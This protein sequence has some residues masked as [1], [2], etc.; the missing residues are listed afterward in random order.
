MPGNYEILVLGTLATQNYVLTVDATTYTRGLNPGETVALGQARLPHGPCSCLPADSVPAVP[1]TAKPSRPRLR[2]TARLTRG[3]CPQLFMKCCNTAASA[4]PV[5]KAANPG[6]YLGD[7]STSYPDDEYPD[8]C[9][10]HGVAC[11]RC[12]HRLRRAVAN[13]FCGLSPHTLADAAAGSTASGCFACLAA[14][15]PAAT[16]ALPAGTST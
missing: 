12:S 11:D 14:G 13:R 10:L 3:S 16:L 4:C 8:F 2:P 6:V 1:T 15:A 7:S 9:Q 5:L